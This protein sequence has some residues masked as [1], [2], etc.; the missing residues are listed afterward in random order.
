MKPSWGWAMS[1][2]MCETS[3]QS[4]P[5]SMEYPNLRAE[6]PVAAIGRISWRR[7]GGGHC[8]LRLWR[9]RL[10]LQGGAG[11]EGASGK[12]SPCHQLGK[13]IVR[14]HPHL[15]ARSSPCSNYGIRYPFCLY[16]NGRGKAMAGRPV[17]RGRNPRVRSSTR[18]TLNAVGP[19]AGRSTLV[20]H[21]EFVV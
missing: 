21:G 17:A 6:I 12:E 14:A 16:T 11:H 2:W 4:K 1:I 9:R 18:Q 3:C 15:L 8:R 7:G 13:R 5:Y 19:A 10:R 20:R